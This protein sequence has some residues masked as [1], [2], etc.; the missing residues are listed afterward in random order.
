MT[1]EA[2]HLRVAARQRA[3]ERSH[4]AGEGR[5]LSSHGARHVIKRSDEQGAVRKSDGKYESLLAWQEDVSTLHL[6]EKQLAASG[7]QIER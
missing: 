4:E 1:I 7:L 2:L 6:G 5:P 3:R